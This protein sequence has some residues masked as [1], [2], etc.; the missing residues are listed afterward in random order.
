MPYFS[1]EDGE[2]ASNSNP[3]LKRNVLLSLFL[4]VCIYIYVRI[5]IYII[6]IIY[7]PG[8]EGEGGGGVGFLLVVPTMH[9][10]H[11]FSSET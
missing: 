11:C 2:S 1:W 6:G 9:F 4:Y 5:Y 3:Y 10:G 7:P 8:P